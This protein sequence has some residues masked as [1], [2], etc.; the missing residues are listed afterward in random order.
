MCKL[1]LITEEFQ[2]N[3]YLIERFPSMSSYVT[4]F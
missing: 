3:Y 4:M 1:L 2:T